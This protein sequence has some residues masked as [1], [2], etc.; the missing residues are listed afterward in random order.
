MN[1][2]LRNI[3]IGFSAIRSSF[4]R[5]FLTSIGLTIG[6]FT[7]SIVTAAVS[8][9]DREFAKSI[10]TIGNDKIYVGRMP[11]SFEFD[12]WNYRNRPEIKEEQLDYINQYSEYITLSSMK[13]I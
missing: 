1:K 11:W 2:I 12:W 10:E 3:L 6:I 7:V 9:V 5:V 8:S 4:T 13:Q